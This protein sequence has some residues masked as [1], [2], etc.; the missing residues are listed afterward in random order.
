MLTHFGIDEFYDG[1]HVFAEFCIDQE[2]GQLLRIEYDDD[3]AVYR[4]VIDEM[5]YDAALSF[6][7]SQNSLA[8]LVI[9]A[10]IVEES[11]WKL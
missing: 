11:S 4:E 5:L 1:E 10:D 7:Y 2:T 6:Y 8:S 3:G 9:A